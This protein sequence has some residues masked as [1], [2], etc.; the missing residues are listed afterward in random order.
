M[1]NI[2]MRVFLISSLLLSLVHNYILNQGSCAAADG[3]QQSPVNIVSTNSLYYDEKYF[4]LL[5]N[6]Y[7]PLTSQSNWTVL[8]TERA[9]GFAPT[10]NISNFGT[11][12]FVKDWSLTNFVLQKILFRVGTEHSIDGVFYDAELQLIHTVDAN[13]YNPGRR[14][15]FGANYLVISVPFKITEDND[16]SAN[17][18][19]NLTNLLGFSNGT[20]NTIMKR[21]SF[22]SMIQHQPS[23]LYQGSLNYDQCQ[24]AWWLLFSQY[25]LIKRTDYNNLV[26]VT[27]ANIPLDSDNKYVRSQS[28]LINPV[29]RN[30]NDLNKFTPRVTLLNFD[31]ATFLNTNVL[32]IMAIVLF[33]LF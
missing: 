11:A 30:W 12:L 23:Y 25:H 8:T 27:R 9:I 3:I 28:P 14:V 7:D 29:Y 31:S 32:I 20:S 2:S 16:P 6:N 10:A 4:R 19:F 33:F 1:V 21:T 26:S 13:Y 18:I 15:D 17:R 5:S 22:V 24:P